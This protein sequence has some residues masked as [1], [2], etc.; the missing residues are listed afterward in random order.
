MTATSTSRLLNLLSLLQTGREWPGSLL[1]ERLGISPRTVRRDVDRLREMGYRIDATMGPIGGYKLDAGSEL[2]PLLFD[3]DQVIALAIALQSATV[4][5]VGI[6][7]A[8]LRALTT[9]RQVMPSRLRHRLTALDFTAIPGKIGGTT[10]GAVSPEVLVAVSSA[11]RAQ[12]VLRFDHAGRPRRVEPHHLVVFEGRWYLVGWDLDRSDWRIYRVDRLAPRAPTGPRFTPRLIP[13]GDV[14]SF[15][16]GQ[17]K[18]SKRGDSWPCVGKVILHLP[19]RAV[20]PFA[21]DGVVEDLGDD[22]CSLEGGSWSWIALAASLNRFDTAIEVLHPAELAAAFGELAARNATTARSSR[23]QGVLVVI[24]GLPGVGKSAVADEVARMLGAVHLSID[25]VEEALLACGLQ[26]G[27]TTGVA[28]YEAVRAAAE[29]NLR[30]GRTVI[31]D[32]VNDS[33]PAR[34]TWRRASA[35]TGTPLRFFVLDL[36][37]TAEHRR[38]IEGRARGLAHVGEPSWSDIRSRSEA[39]EPW[40]GPHERIDASAT[41]AAV[42]ASILHR[43][44]TAEPRTP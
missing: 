44:E 15:V 39:F 6:E 8:A 7:E 4:S 21:G 25:S 35:A 18:G 14:A 2:P 13:G 11:V 16:S 17:F 37:D 1:A 33:E 38:R 12:H 36:A 28:A 34:D 5:G 20:L 24:S 43:L 27:W 23:Q 42:A 32:A 22:R 3:D 31:V 9:V 29:Q 26:P 40:Q 19:A 41:L 30:L 10:R